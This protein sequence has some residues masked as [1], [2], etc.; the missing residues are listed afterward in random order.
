MVNERRKLP[1][2][3]CQ[4]Q[5]IDPAEAEHQQAD[6]QQPCGTLST[7]RVAGEESFALRRCLKD[8]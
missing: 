6:G 5:Q 7:D 3:L 2:S 4:V 1:D 8:M